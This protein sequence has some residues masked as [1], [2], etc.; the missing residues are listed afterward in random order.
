MKLNSFRKSTVHHRPE[1]LRE[2]PFTGEMTMA[3]GA[4]QSLDSN[5]LAV[6]FCG[7]GDNGPF[8]DKLVDRSWE[9]AQAGSSLDEVCQLIENS[10]KEAYREFGEIYQRG[11]C[12]HAELIYGVKLSGDS[13]LFSAYGPVVTEK[14]E[15]CSGGIGCYMANFLAARMYKDY[16]NLHQCVILAAYILLQ[17]KEHVEGCGG[18][19]HIAVLRNDGVSGKVDWRR[20]DA[21]NK[22]VEYA[23]SEAGELVL[24]KANLSKSKEEFNETVE[25]IRDT[26]E[27]MRDAQIQE[28]ER[29]TSLCFSF[30]RALGALYKGPETDEY[31]LPKPSDEEGKQ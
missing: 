13:K 7:A 17:A 5:E 20:V 23:D 12:P 14:Y 25:R 19:S 3:A 1:T 8:I 22:L 29:A 11:Y 4:P 2:I 26:L 21:I 9:E 16:R 30:G 15:Y 24:Q 27:I 28:L 6:A 10:I 31:G 18:E